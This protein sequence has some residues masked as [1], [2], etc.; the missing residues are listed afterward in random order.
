LVQHARAVTKYF[1]ATPSLERSSTDSN[2]PISMG[3]PAFT[4]G[5]GGMGLNHHAMTE[6][7]INQG[8]VEGIQRV[9]LILLAE[10]GLANGD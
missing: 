7:W 5:G 6:G 2:I 8:G 1:G 3:I 9:T 10:A 4:T